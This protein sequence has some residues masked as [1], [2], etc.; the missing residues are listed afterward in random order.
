MIHG[1]RLFPWVTQH[2]AKLQDEGAYKA[3]EYADC[4]KCTLGDEQRRRVRCAWVPPER[5][6]GDALVPP[7]YPY[8]RP[9]VC[10]GYLTSLPQVIEAARAY[11]WRKD[12]ALSQFYEGRLTGIAKYCIDIIAGEFK[13]VEQ[14][15]IR[16]SREK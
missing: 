3:D 7:A 9:D 12:G 13:A 15:A 4:D 2:R 10:C 5:R 16:Q 1:L 8:Q 11:T 6:T 14:Y